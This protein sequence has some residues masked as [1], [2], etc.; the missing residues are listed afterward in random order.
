MKRTRTFPLAPLLAAAVAFGTVAAGSPA[1]ADPILPTPDAA[2]GVTALSLVDRDREDPWA[3]G[4]RRELAVTVTYPAAATTGRVRAPYL[5]GTGLP[6]NGH[7]DAPVAASGKRSLP[8]VLFSPGFYMP[9]TLSTGTAEHLAS[10]GYV[11]ISI[12]HTGD[13]LATVFPD[14]RVVPQR[15]TDSYSEAT[16]RKAADTRVADAKF[17]IDVVESLARGDDNATQTPLPD[18]LA[19]AVDPTRI[20]MFGHS[21]GGATTAEVLRT[22]PRL[23]AGVNLDGALFYGTAP[24][25]IVTEGASGPLLSIISS[26]HADSPEGRERFWDQYFRT[27]RG[28]SRVYA[29]ADTGHASFTDAEHFVPQSV[30]DLPAFEIPGG[31]SLGTAPRQEVTRT[32]DGLVTAMFDRH[33][34]DRDEQVLENPTPQYPLIREIR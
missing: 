18:G 9:R 32:I 27:D 34:R 24:S 11:V 30:P 20:G 33:L 4:T 25:P 19:D 1:S 16:L 12:D 14:G 23:D 29:I 8:V 31:L 7:L 13:A 21:M 28:W 6:T 26:L 15:M 5:P 10:R 22:E 2:V 17:V 3:P